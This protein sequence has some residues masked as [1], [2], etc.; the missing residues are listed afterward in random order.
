MRFN[1]RNSRPRLLE[2]SYE[3]G[4]CSFKC[5]SPF[6]RTDKVLGLPR[7]C[8]ISQS[9]ISGGCTSLIQ[10]L[11]VSVNRPLKDVLQEPIGRQLLKLSKEEGKKVV[12][13]CAPQPNAAEENK[14]NLWGYFCYRG[15]TYHFDQ[16]S[17]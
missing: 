4:P 13:L 9:L 3:I 1:R 5:C 11:D 2:P 10:V 17:R 6:H 7:S 12:D 14:T 16:G 15:S 8:N